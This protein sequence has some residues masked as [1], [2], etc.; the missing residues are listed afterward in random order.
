MNKCKKVMK[1][2][3]ILNICETMVIVNQRNDCNTLRLQK[4]MDWLII[5]TKSLTL[6]LS[7]IFMKAHG[8]PV[9]SILGSGCG[10]TYNK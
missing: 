2:L 5:Y 8:C 1:G 4:I 3:D 9:F 10:I 7:N 6:F